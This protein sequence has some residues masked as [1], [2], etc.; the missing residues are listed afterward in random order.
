QQKQAIEARDV[1]VAVSAAAGS[2]KT[3]TL[4][5]RIIERV[6]AAD[7]S[8]DI[9]RILAVTYTKAAAAEIISRLEKA[10]TKKLAENPANKHIARQSLLVSSARVSTIHSFCLSVLRENFS[11]VSLPSDISTIDDTPLDV[12]MRSTMEE[13][14][15]EC[16]ERDRE[17]GTK[18]YSELFDTFGALGNGKA[19]LKTLADLYEYLNYKL[20][21]LNC[22]DDFIQ[23]YKNIDASNFFDSCWGK[24]LRD[25][26]FG[27]LS[28]YKK[29]L[30]DGLKTAEENAPYD[31]LTD[32][33]RKDVNYIDLLYGAFI[34][35]AD[36]FEICEKVGDFTSDNIP[37]KTVKNGIKAM[38]FYKDEH[39]AFGK[40]AEEFLK[41]YYSFTREDISY[42]SRHTVEML[43]TLKEFLTEFD[44]RFRAEK[45]RR[46]VVSFADMERFALEILWDAEKDAPSDVAL[47]YRDEFDEIYIDEYQD[48]NEVQDKI[49]SLISRNN[50]K[51]CVGDVKQSIYGFR[52]AVPDIFEKLLD[53]REKYVDGFSG[54]SAKIF[55]SSNFR[56]SYE[57]LD[58]CNCVFD[59]LMN[60]GQKRYGEDEKFRTVEPRHC[61]DVEI[62]AFPTGK[63]PSVSPEAEY[64][65]R[66]IAS[67][68]EEGRK[69]SD[70]AILLRADKRTKD[71]ETALN[72]LNIP[73]VNGR[74]K[75]IFENAEVLLMLSLLNVIDNPSRDVYLAATLKSPLFGV[76]LDELI[77][78][79][80]SADGSLYDALCDFTEKT[81]FAAGKKFLAFVDRFRALAQGMP[82]DELIWQ[83][84]LET[85]I[86]SLVGSGEDLREYEKE[87]AQANLIQL[88]NYARKFG[89][90]SY[91]GLYD[92]ISF[93]NNAIEGKTDIKIGQ[94]NTAENAV[95][96]MTVH[97]SKG[98]EFPVCFF[99]DTSAIYNRS[100]L[101]RDVIVG[102]YG[103]VP[104]LVH[105]SGLGKIKTLQYLVSL[106]PKKREIQSEEIR[107]LYVALT[108]AKDKL[109]ITGTSASALD[110]APE[111]VNET[112]GN[113]LTEYSINEITNN[114]KMICVAAAGKNKCKPA[115]AVGAPS[116]Q[117]EPPKGD[118][119]STLV[120]AKKLVR[121]RLSFEYPYGG[122][123]SVPSK[124]AVSRLY[125]DMLDDSETEV[126]TASFDYVPRFLASEDEGSTAAERG[127]AT[128]T[129]M[130]FFDFGR[131]EQYGVK[132][133][134]KYLAE[135]KFIFDSDVDK[136]DVRGLER[137]FK[138]DLAKKIR[139]SSEVL[140]EKRFM[141]SFPAE[142]FTSSDELKTKLEDEKLLVQ[143]VIDCAYRDE[144][145]K[146][147]LIDYK[148]DHFKR[149]TPRE[150]IEKTLRERHT[151]QLGYYRRA[152]EE[153]FGEVSHVY[154]YS[155]ALGDVV[156]I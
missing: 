6:C 14:I 153:M 17:S 41:K 152:C 60:V 101:M 147:V 5:Q 55:L 80:R 119:A 118:A 86:F 156:E 72:R 82:C 35:G 102:K 48:T 33:F 54:D 107:I 44:A 75:K 36:Y 134:I 68:V 34:S 40:K 87:Q 64:V 85:D 62:A 66:R 2:G 19:H 114:F 113:D 74:K 10:L 52:G 103:I 13:L 100:D 24:E 135:K 45:A 67:L 76:T 133:E 56:S 4:T 90:S 109:I 105:D 1:S 155:F 69:F 88:Y 3:S 46:H 127:T 110:V 96:I 132:R 123:S 27:M 129:F 89:G 142:E 138:S 50:N 59:K 79:R 43:S 124:V 7:G 151:R 81:G 120:G 111:G 140:R 128:H 47:R 30:G 122:L 143:G 104:K 61:G 95:R 93:I 145:G 38:A 39:K 137:F 131:V 58:F 139:A 99:S 106:I 15:D 22:I 12:L 11:R 97:E 77:Y 26:T 148:T 63:D 130:Q 73:F 83:I 20:N 125:P 42:A 25:Y 98:L 8:G 21:F 9:S 29:T 92:F 136:I 117:P 91:R 154:I 28:H 141:M 149:G 23:L 37:R 78:I 53:E 108:R 70:I 146:L 126:K 116:S 112:A 31:Y 51:F 115:S 32:M 18:K 49:F 16:F 84:Y 71:F 65:A 150:E 144:D 121:D 94:F 57:I